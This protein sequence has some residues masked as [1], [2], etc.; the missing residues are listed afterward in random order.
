ML[1]AWSTGK[2]VKLG[3]TLPSNVRFQLMQE[4]ICNYPL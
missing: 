3:E 4:R 2:E 1:L